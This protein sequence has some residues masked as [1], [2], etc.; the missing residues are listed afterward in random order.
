MSKFWS[1]VS[2]HELRYRNSFFASNALKRYCNGPLTDLFYYF[3]ARSK[4]AARI[5]EVQELL[6]DPILTYKELHSVQCLSYFNA[7]TKVHQTL[8]SLLHYLGEAGSGNKDP[9]AV[10]I[11]RKVSAVD[12]LI[13]LQHNNSQK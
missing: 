9:K 3:K 1:N 12:S 11:K 2:I 13:T 8:D 7:L 10:G 6:Q 5:K 4:R